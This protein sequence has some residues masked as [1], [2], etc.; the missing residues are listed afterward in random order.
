MGRTAVSHAPPPVSY[1]R[2]CFEIGDNSGRLPWRSRPLEHF[3]Q[4]REDAAN[5]N[6]RFPGRAAGWMTPF[7]LMVRF[8]FEG[9]TVRML[10][11][12]VAW[13]IST[14]THPVGVIAPRDGDPTNM[15]PANLL[16][17]SRGWR[18]RGGPSLAERRAADAAVLAAMRQHPGA[19][20]A[21]I[22]GIAGSGKPS[23]RRRLAKLAAQG[24]ACGPQCLPSRH[25]ALTGAGLTLAA[26]ATPLVDA[27][28]REVLA[29]LRWR[30]H[31]TIASLARRVERCEPTARRRLQGLAERGLVVNGAGW[32]L[33]GP[34]LAAIGGRPE[35]WVKPLAPPLVH[36]RDA[37]V[38]SLS[39]SRFG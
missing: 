28:D 33:T 14:G 8:T 15:R 18:R 26:S 22:A 36:H 5:W 6:A 12:R 19:T 1:L 23:A 35:P 25:W 31:C 16:E 20:I 13:A 3:G 39:I 29:A 24:L 11:S 7:G 34:G 37:L 32:S 2:Q 30:D 21:E 4:R 10:A 38:G 9:R 17:R 27:L